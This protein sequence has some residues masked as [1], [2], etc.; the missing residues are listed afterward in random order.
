[1][2]ILRPLV[3]LRSIAPRTEPK[4]QQ[5]A[6]Y[7]DRIRLYNIHSIKTTEQTFT[8]RCSQALSHTGAVCSSQQSSC[9]AHHSQSQKRSKRKRELWRKCRALAG[10]QQECG[11]KV[12]AA[13]WG[14]Q[15]RAGS[16]LHCLAYLIKAGGSEKQEDYSSCQRAHLHPSLS[17]PE[18][19]SCPATPSLPN[20]FSL[21]VH[22][23]R[24]SE[25][26]VTQQSIME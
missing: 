3:H 13:A 11:T 19:S 24:E 9:K 2:V 5:T 25:A 18:M 14:C 16:I 21:T 26:P 7:Q 6:C 1:M 4:E 12:T 8:C 15:M 17:Q 10:K 23:S 22:L 20:D